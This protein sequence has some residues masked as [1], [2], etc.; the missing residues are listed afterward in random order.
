MEDL[1]KLLSAL[2]WAITGYVDASILKKKEP[3]LDVQISSGLVPKK[4]D[5]LRIK[6]LSTNSLRDWR[7]LER[8]IKKEVLNFKSKK[9]A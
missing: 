6:A 7:R 1:K 9:E 5:A 8:A 3:E 2:E 4:L